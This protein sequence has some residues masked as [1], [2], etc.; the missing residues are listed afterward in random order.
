VAHR[1]CRILFAVL[2]NG[3]EFDPARIGVEEGTSRAP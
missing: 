2:R 3:S 1:L